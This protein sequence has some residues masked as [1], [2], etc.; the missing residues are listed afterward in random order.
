MASSLAASGG[1]WLVSPAGGARDR[2]AIA[3]L[4][5]QNTLALSADAPEEY[6]RQCLDIPVDF[7]HLISPVPFATGRF[8]VARSTGAGC[9][10]IIGCAGVMPPAAGAVVGSAS[11][12]WRLTAVSVAPGARRRGLARALVRR[13][14]AAAV[15]SGATRVDC[16][17]LLE[18]MAPAWGLYESLGFVRVDA[19]LDYTRPRPMT[20]LTYLLDGAAAAAAGAWLAEERGAEAGGHGESAITSEVC[21]GVVAPGGRGVSSG[22]VQLRAA[23][24]HERERVKDFVARVHVDASAFDAR[25]RA[26]QIA[27]LPTDFPELWTDAAWR[28]SACW[29]VETAGTLVGA[30]GLRECSKDGAPPGVLEI[31]Y[32]F[33]D[34]GA[35]GAGLGGRLLTAA[36]EAARTRRAPAVRLLTLTDQYASACRMYEGRGFALR[37]VEIHDMYSVSHFELV[38]CC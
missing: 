3:A 2:A 19:S 7:A 22:A 28:A 36:I 8:F 11:S 20:V 4:V 10:D 12:T 30:V 16:L 37:G 27:D 23:Q 21:G 18:L 14:V 13:A 25:S 17:T 1:A 35:R 34:E 31:G 5:I 26:A 29:R 15:E 6:V 24:P 32:L 33:V 9:G 38:L